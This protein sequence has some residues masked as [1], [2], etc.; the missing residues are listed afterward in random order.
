MHHSLMIPFQDNIQSR[1]IGI[2][3]ANPKS[4]KYLNTACFFFFQIC[5][6]LFPEK[7]FDDVLD[8]T[9]HGQR[10]FTLQQYLN[11]PYPP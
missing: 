8:V 3:S 10:H 4:V 6:S 7:H 11:F 9:L 2:S 1:L 5:N